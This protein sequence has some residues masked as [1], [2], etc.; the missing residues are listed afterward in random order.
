[1]GGNVNCS[2]RPLN[3]THQR[4]SAVNSPKEKSQVW[5][6]SK[7]THSVKGGEREMGLA[8]TTSPLHT[9]RQKEANGKTGR[10]TG[11]NNTK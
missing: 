7:R 10:D 6:G 8:Q 11:T 4:R 2:E 5:W 1:M 9:R 3:T